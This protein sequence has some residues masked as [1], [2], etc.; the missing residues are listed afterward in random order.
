MLASWKGFGDFSIMVPCRLFVV[1]L[2]MLKMTPLKLHFVDFYALFLS[3][4]FM[5]FAHQPC[6]LFPHRAGGNSMLPSHHSFTP[7][8]K[9]FVQG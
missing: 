2:Q 3:H 6:P 4:H 7:I 1:Y 5:T 9:P 8:L